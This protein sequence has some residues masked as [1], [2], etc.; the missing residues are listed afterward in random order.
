MLVQEQSYVRRVA[1][2]L[3]KQTFVVKTLLILV[4]FLYKL[5]L[6]WSFIEKVVFELKQY[7]Q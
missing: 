1:I 2:L 5:A 7:V 3:E 6:V 4:F